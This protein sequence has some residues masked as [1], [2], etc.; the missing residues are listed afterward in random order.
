MTRAVRRSTQLDEPSPFQYPVGDGLGQV[1]VVKYPTP[2]VQALVRG[3]DHRL[4]V[5]IAMIDHLE[6]H[7]GGV[8]AIGQ[9]PHLV[10]DEDVR[11]HVRH[12]GLG[13]PAFVR[14]GGELLDELGRGGKAGI[15]AV[16]DG[17][18][19]DRYG[20]VR[21]TSGFK[22]PVRAHCSAHCSTRNGKRWFWSV[23]RPGR[24]SQL[25]GYAA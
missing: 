1:R 3:E 19:S 4:L 12:Q 22:L 2:L 21:F 24:V 15:V 17:T 13:Q 25:T 16:L 9:V 14:R 18:I 6:E 10:D 23:F 20:E 7:V 5:Q 8:G 11:L